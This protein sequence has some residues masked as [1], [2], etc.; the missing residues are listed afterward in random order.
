[1]G[2]RTP[3]LLLCLSVFL[4][5]LAPPMLCAVKKEKEKKE[6]KDKQV[7]TVVLPVVFYM[8]ETRWG[9]GG[10][11]LLTYRPKAAP[12]DQRPSSLL[13][14]AYYTQNKQ[15]G[16]EISPE[17]YLKNEA[18][19]VQGYFKVSKFPD[20]FWGIGNNTP[21]LEE[22]LED[23]DY[24]NYTPKIFNFELSVQRQILKEQ[25]LYAGVQLKY[26]NFDIVGMAP[27]GLLVSGEVP[28]STGGTLTSLGFLITWDTRDNIFYPFTGNLF[29]L[30]VDFYTPAFGSDFE[31]TTIK[32]DL[33]KYFT[34]F[35]SHVL[36]VQALLWNVSGEPTFRHLAE[37]GGEQ[38]MRG[39]YTGRYRDHSMY[40]LQA[41]YR[42]KVWK[43]I[44]MVAFAGVSNVADKIGNLGFDN[45]KYSVGLGLRFCVVPKERTNIRL[46]YGFGKG[47]SGMYITAREA[48]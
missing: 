12:P 4:I 5:S 31:F 33:R 39:Y 20:K 16:I 38:I 44:G 6:K 2:K 10:G 1:M 25:R 27:L 19:I 28:G 23:K 45:I 32:M 46:D 24:L 47:T 9:V 26:E 35:P 41:E 15:Y 18:Y 21:D 17:V 42:V 37:I 34:L 29:Q 48:F 30:N 11:G 3:L 40:A 8:P 7:S 13:F 22:G 43:F 14:Q 36:A